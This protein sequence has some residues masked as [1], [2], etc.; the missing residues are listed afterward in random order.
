MAEQGN[1]ADNV[2][3]LMITNHT[4]TLMSFMQLLEIIR[5]PDAEVLGYLI[6]DAEAIE[7]CFRSAFDDVHRELLLIRHP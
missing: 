3:D 6:E 5:H 2:L 4:Q 1:L 7:R